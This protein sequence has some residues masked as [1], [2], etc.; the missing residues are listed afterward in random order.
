MGGLYTPGEAFLKA[1]SE[2]KSDECREVLVI[3]KNHESSHSSEGEVD[4]REDGHDLGLL[5]N[6]IQNQHDEHYMDN[7][8]RNQVSNRVMG[9]TI[10]DEEDEDEHEDEDGILL[11]RDG[12]IQTGGMEKQMQTQTQIQ[13]QQEFD[14]FFDSNDEGFSYYR[15]ALSFLLKFG[16]IHPIRILALYYECKS[17]CLYTLFSMAEMSL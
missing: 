12:T 8:M 11:N 1:P 17:F 14:D 4:E 13:T 3:R 9:M 5:A 15:T 10:Q 7:K 2:S 16:W 6:I